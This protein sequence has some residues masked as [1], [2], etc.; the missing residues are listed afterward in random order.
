MHRYTEQYRK[1]KN[2][3]RIQGAWDGTLPTLTQIFPFKGLK[4]QSVL[5]K[6]EYRNLKYTSQ[7]AKM[8]RLWV[9]STILQMGNGR[10][11]QAS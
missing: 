6:F 3:S 11:A 4:V 2:T 9:G 7:E 5:Y 10:A 1:R 8:I